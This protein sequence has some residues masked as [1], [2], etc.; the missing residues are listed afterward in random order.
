MIDREAFGSDVDYLSDNQGRRVTPLA[1]PAP[2]GYVFLPPPG[3]QWQGSRHNQFLA[4]TR[5]LGAGME[6]DET[7]D[8]RENDDEEGVFISMRRIVA[9]ADVSV[10]LL[11]G[12]SRSASDGVKEKSK[13][14]KGKDKETG[15]SDDVVPGS[16]GAFTVHK[17]E[18]YSP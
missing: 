17:D 3:Y 13:N 16:V 1:R 6:G 4:R 8:L 5:A 9:A 14:G 12:G 7:A 10:G 2:P 11:E 15:G 18:E